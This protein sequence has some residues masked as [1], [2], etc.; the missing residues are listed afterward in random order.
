MQISS[1][2]SA[3]VVNDLPEERR[4]SGWFQAIGRAVSRLWTRSAGRSVAAL[5]ERDAAL[6]AR[7]DEAAQTWNAHLG[8]AQQQMRDATQALLQGFAQILEQLDAITDPAGQGARSGV[9]AQGLDRR[10]HTLEHCESQLRGLI[11]NFH[12]FVKSRDDVLSS[13]RSLATASHSLREMAEDVAKIARQTNLLS[14]NAAIEAARAGTSGRGFAVVAAEVRRLSTE[15]GDTGKRIHDQVNDFG[16]RMRVALAEAAEHATQDAGV[17]SASEQTIVQVVEQVD[18]AVSQL[19]QRAADLSARGEAVRAQVEQ[20]MVAFQFQ[21]RVH[22]I[23]DQVNASILS[24]TARLQQSLAGGVAPGAQEWAALLSA[25]YTT[26]EQR[27]VNAGTPSG[28]NA[29]AAPQASSDTTF[30]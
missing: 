30:F 3:V 18:N 28:A 19:H 17:I 24:A 21:D 16:G 29:Q 26:D 6:A 22:Q 25:G 10:A 20:L 14:L 2:S 4:V 9:T 7:L 27:A 13:V 12:G 23:M 11:E 15:S 8:T 5:A 1:L